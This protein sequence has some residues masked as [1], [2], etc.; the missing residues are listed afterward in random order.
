MKLINLLLVGL[1]PM[2]LGTAPL[3]KRGEKDLIDDNYIV[4]MKKGIDAKGIQ[5]HYNSMQ[6]SSLKLVGGKKGFVRKF[7]VHDFNA[8][9]IECDDD[10]LQAIRGHDM[11][12][13]VTQ[14]ARV[15]LQAPVPLPQTVGMVP[16]GVEQGSWGL[17]RVSHRGPGIGGYVGAGVNPDALPSHAYII[18]TGIRTSHRQFGNRASWGKTFVDGADDTDDNGHGTHV[19]GTVGGA[20][21]GVDNTTLLFALKVLDA[22]G[23]GSDSSMIAGVDW[24]VEHARNA[25]SLSRSVINLSLGVDRVDPALTDVIEAAYSAGMTVVAAAGN[26]GADAC[27][28]SPASAL[29]AIAVGATDETDHR[30][31]YSN[32]GACVDIFAPGNNIRSTWHDDDNAFATLMGTSMAAPHVAGV[33]AYLMAREDLPTPAQVWTRILALATKDKLLDVNGS[34]NR[35]AFNGNPAELAL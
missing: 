3:I 1:A 32:L 30:A 8:Y 9:H 24:A 29:D 26:H 21:V 7:Q 14:D 34:P 28:F 16:A 31:G 19:A 4:V 25:S 12:D 11:V 10:M 15:S 13:Y 20:T 33:A 22:N 27:S 17:G 6:T 35:L 2:A 23:V 18:D 5:A